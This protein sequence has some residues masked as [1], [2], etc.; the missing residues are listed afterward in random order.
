MR[1]F[2]HLTQHELNP[3]P[4]RR[5]AVSGSLAVWA[6]LG[7]LADRARRAGS[8]AE[9]ALALL[10]A[11]AAVAFA[12]A[13]LAAR[14]V[15]AR[16]FVLVRRAQHRRR[17]LLAERQLRKAK[18]EA[19]ALVAQAE[20]RLQA[21]RRTRQ[22]SKYG[23]FELFDDRLQGPDWEL[24]LPS[25]RAVVVPPDAVINR[26][27]GTERFPLPDAAGHGRRNR[28][29]V[30]S[31]KGVSAQ[32]CGPRDEQAKDFARLLNVAALNASNFDRQRRAETEAATRSLE[33]A[34]AMAQQQIAEARARRNATQRD[35]SSIED[36]RNQVVRAAHETIALERRREL[37]AQVRARRRPQTGG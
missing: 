13:V 2:K 10:A 3:E 4:L 25:V 33:D 29:V 6:I 24:S 20:K 27:G 34:E 32:E 26:G 9:R 21:V 36:A 12:L 5:L 37:L 7:M 11:R 28:L 17:C 8:P 19:E 16:A 31:R 30:Q 35:T 1:S 14:V 22:L 23:S 15:H 18:R